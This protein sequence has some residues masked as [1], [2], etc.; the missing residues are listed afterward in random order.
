VTVISRVG[1]ILGDAHEHT[2]CLER[3][4]LSTSRRGVLTAHSRSTILSRV[5]GRRGKALYFVGDA[6]KALRRMPEDVKDCFGQALLDLQ[7]GDTPAIA[8]PFGEGVSPKVWKLVDDHDKEAYR[9][10]YTLTLPDAVY[11]LHA[12]QKKSKSGR[13]TPQSDRALVTARMK[14]AVAHHRESQQTR[15]PT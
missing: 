6:L 1:A 4:P 2:V 5:D 11:V 7:F 14:D 9:V 15:S 12:F 13:A 3:Y 10:A 8:K